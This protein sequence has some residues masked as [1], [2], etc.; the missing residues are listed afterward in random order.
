MNNAKMTAGQCNCIKKEITLSKHL[1]S[2]E[3]AKIHNT[4][5]HEIAHALVGAEAGHGPI[6]QKKARE[7]GCD[8]KRCFTGAICKPKWL[9]TCSCKKTQIS[10]HRVNQSV[11]KSYVCKHCMSGLIKVEQ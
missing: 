1:T 4:I 6:W 11:L 3:E 5:L 7:I 2:Q 8:G 10:R 9:I